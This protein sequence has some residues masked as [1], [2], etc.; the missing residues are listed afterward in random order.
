VLHAFRPAWRPTL[1]SLGPALLAAALALAIHGLGLRGT[2]VAAATY[3]VSEV[4]VYGLVLWDS[5]WYGGNLPLGYSVVFPLVGALIGLVATGVAATF[6]ATWAFDRITVEAWGRRSAGSWY[7]GICT[8]L[9]V[10]I[11]QLPFLTG[12]AFGLLALYA[13]LK[14][15]V[16]P[17][18]V[19]AALSALC[20]PLAAAFLAMAC[21]AWALDRADRRRSSLVVAAAA[22]VV[23]GALGVV[24]PGTGS[25]PFPWG[26]MVLTLA[27][28][29]T[30]LLPF[31]PANPVI[32]WGALL[33]AASTFGSFVIPNPLGGNAPRLAG[34]V[35]IPL[36]AALVTLRDPTGAGLTPAPGVGRSTRTRPGAGVTSARPGAGVTSARPGAGV[37]SARPGA[38]VTSAR[39]GAGAS[40][41]VRRL[42]ARTG[43]GA[44]RTTL[45]VAVVGGLA[46]WQWAPGLNALSTA[47]VRAASTSS[48]YQP[49]LHQILDHSTGPV[50]VEAVPTRDHW[51]SV[52]LAP[53]LSLARGWERQL[54][55]ADN[56]LFYTPGGL[57]EASY[58]TWLHDNGVT[59]VALPRTTLDYAA[60]AEA[61][62]LRH[63]VPG[64][65]RV[66]SSAD[67]VLWR[68][69]GGPGL[70]SGPAQLESLD[71]DH[72]TLR[73]DRPAVV[74]VRVRYTRY[75]T[76]AHADPDT[77]LAPGP[78]GWT[79]VEVTHPGQVD[80]AVSLL[81]PDVPNCTKP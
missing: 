67:W 9:Q 4:R 62:L 74:T 21:L 10:A 76:L 73:V 78:D 31:V 55:I 66:W 60:V 15:R 23:V 64:L 25:F 68:V 42:A 57:T 16:A 72:L 22:L 70:V 5:G 27:V 59:W 19:L 63:G 37:T 39:P 29:A 40:A 14:R 71:P 35:G 32:R 26:G 3:R 56:P 2:D 17:A 8:M 47:T 52:Y 38:G 44:L 33:Y 13:L 51:E 6:A 79:K 81:D 53:Q 30:A 28:C 75:W 34:A 18:A 7:F 43:R 77:C 49:V 65:R 54:D 24:F 11:G 36:L 80:L 48:F 61:A 45:A 50:R 58:L 46:V 69:T 20:S 41:R 1:T 12:E